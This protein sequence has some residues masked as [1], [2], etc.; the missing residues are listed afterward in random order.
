MGDL[1]RI[2]IAKSVDA[3]VADYVEAGTPTSAI[4][5]E[6]SRALADY[7]V[8]RYADAMIDTLAELVAF[9]TVHIDGVDNAVNPEFRSMTAYLRTKAEEFDFD[10]A[11][12]GAVVVVG[13]GHA[14]DRLGII[15]HGDVQ[16]AEP[17]KWQ[18][19]PFT[20]DADSEPGRLIARGTEDDKGPI[21]TALYAMKALRDH[22]T[23]LARRIELTIVY[24]EESDWDPIRAFVRD[25]EPPQLNVV[26]DAEYPV[27][28]AEKG[29]GTVHL[30]LPADLDSPPPSDS[31]LESFSGGAFLSQ[32][33]ESAT[34][35]IGAATPEVEAMLREAAGRQEAVHL[36]FERD[37]DT[38]TVESTGRSAHSGS[39]WN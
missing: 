16:P 20:L 18:A 38:L 22:E 5:A 39:P 21:A 36:R 25:V 27:V 31:Y 35:V 9:K 37:G 6:R 33:P 30:S 3:T 8:E 4:P 28:V 34:A 19:D 23:P 15:T 17:T 11:D 2:P 14:T 13:L 24:T 12:H 7:A 1:E 10:F 29:F 26:I 32:V